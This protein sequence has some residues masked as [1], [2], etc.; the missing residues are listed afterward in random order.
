MR[1]RH[2]WT[3]TAA[4]AATGGVAAAIWLRR[5]FFAV[6]VEGHSMSPALSPGDRVLMRRGVRGL[7]PGDLVVVS[8]PD[9]DLGWTAG[10]QSDPDLA[11]AGRFIKRVAAVAGQNNPAALRRGGIVPHGH[12][13]VLGD[14]PHSVDSKQ[15]GPCPLDQVLGVAV[16]LPDGWRADTG[17]RPLPSLQY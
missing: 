13:V 16:R 8:R 7:R 6:T 5:R 4:L 2:L 14:H 17:H 9:P 10:A 1:A 3:L 11:V 12:V 15:Y